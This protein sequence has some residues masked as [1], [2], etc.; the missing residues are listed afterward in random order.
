VALAGQ[1]GVDPETGELRAGL[2][3]QVRQAITNLS[4][5]LDAAG[6]SWDDVIKTTCFLAHIEDFARFDAVYAEFIPEPRPARSTVG[7]G[8]AGDLLVE[9]EALASPRGVV[10]GS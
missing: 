8:L 2:E 6:C 9:I 7:V 10:D 4:A 1:T 3:A 5:V